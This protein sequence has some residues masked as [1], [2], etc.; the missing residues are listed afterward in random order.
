M[1]P[2]TL[3]GAHDDRRHHWP[4]NW[5]LDRSA[6]PRTWSDLPRLVAGLTQVDSIVLAFGFTMFPGYLWLWP[7]GGILPESQGTLVILALLGWLTYAGLGRAAVKAANRRTWERLFAL[8]LLLL[9]ANV[10]S[11]WFTP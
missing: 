3:S 10:G 11:C 9:C 2:S 6:W 5:A 1:K 7:L 8:F 4:E